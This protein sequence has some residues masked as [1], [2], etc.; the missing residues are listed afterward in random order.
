MKEDAPNPAPLTDGRKRLQETTKARI[1]LQMEATGT[2]TNALLS[3]PFENVF[4]I[5]SQPG[6]GSQIPPK[7]VHYDMDDY[8]PTCTAEMSI[9]YFPALNQ[10]VGV[11]VSRVKDGS[12]ANGEPI[13]KLVIED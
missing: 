10:E 1:V 8:C 11:R 4:V 7:L 6:P 9:K 12:K 13:Y 3:Q 2:P 5:D